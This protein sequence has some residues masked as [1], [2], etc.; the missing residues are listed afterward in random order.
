[1]K[2]TLL[3]SLFLASSIT[4]QADNFTLCKST[5]AL[6]TKALCE[7]IPGK[8]DMVSCHCIVKTGY[9]AGTKPCQEVKKTDAGK[10]VY[11]RYY[12]IKSYVVCTNNRP[13]AWC[14]DSP[15]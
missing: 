11:S 4:A 13:W 15:C 6:C 14:L 2:K 1:M 3:F 5:F 8:T 9:S 12:P 7:P 10:M